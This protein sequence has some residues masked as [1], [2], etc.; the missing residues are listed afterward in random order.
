[1]IASGQEKRFKNPYFGE[2][3]YDMYNFM[4]ENIKYPVIARENGIGGVVV[5][6]F[7]IDTSGNVDS[8]MVLNNIDPSL[9]KEAIRIIKLSSGLWKPAKINDSLVR[10][11]FRWDITFK[12]EAEDV[13]FRNATYFYNLGVKYAGLN[14]YQK[15]LYNFEQALIINTEDIDALYN[16]AM[17]KF[18]MSDR[19]GACEYLRKIKELNK[20]DADDLMLKYCK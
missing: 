11:K 19:N 2:H 12:L 15:A 4:H 20:P 8:I 6:T 7:I 5:T 17:M 16:A 1:M 10:I 14:D 18:K 9:N 3:D 13:E